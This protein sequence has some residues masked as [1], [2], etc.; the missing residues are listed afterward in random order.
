MHAC[1]LA[2]QQQAAEKKG[3]LTGKQFFQSQEAE[4]GCVRDQLV[5]LRLFVC[6][7]KASIIPASGCIMTITVNST[8]LIA[9]QALSVC[10]LRLTSLCA[11]D[12]TLLLQKLPAAF[13]VASAAMSWHCMQPCMQPCPCHIQKR[14]ILDPIALFSSI[15]AKA[16]LT[17]PLDLQRPMP[18]QQK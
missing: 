1:S 14:R 13:S 6:Q 8:F 11:P 9:L 3:R 16:H 10:R 12:C 2:E 7:L 5:G 18:F 17:S 15:A 4:V